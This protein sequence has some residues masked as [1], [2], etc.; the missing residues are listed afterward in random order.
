LETLAAECRRRRCAEQAVGIGADSVRRA[1]VA[2][3]LGALLDFAIGRAIVLIAGVVRAG[4]GLRAR[5]TVAAGRRLGIRP[6]RI[7]FPRQI[8]LAI[9]FRLVLFELS[10]DV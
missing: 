10:R 2:A 9:G 7:V 6:A 1:A 4:V 8:D 3:I 5:L